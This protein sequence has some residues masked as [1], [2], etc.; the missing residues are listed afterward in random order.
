MIITEQQEKW[1]LRT[2]EIFF[3]YGIKSITMDD[4]ARELGISKKTLYQFV[5]NKNDLV[6]KVVEQHIRNEVRQVE[7]WQEE[8]ADA[9]DEMMLV[10]NNVIKDMQLIKS[11][12]VFDMQKYHREAWDMM[13]N[14]QRGHMMEKVRNNL[15]RGI[16]EGVYRPDFDVET[17][18]RLH[19][20]QSF[21]LFDEEWFPNPE[22][23][24]DALFREYILH[25]LHGLLS[26]EGRR[27]LRN[28]DIGK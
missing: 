28:K 5:S 22:F 9:L 12:I 16:R 11:N 25:Y 18:T 24:R 3:R 17:V 1:L 19:V 6:I 2:A 10:I 15:I 27:R 26:D 21:L 14:Y 7:C 20:A 4:V 23:P 8:A 13:K